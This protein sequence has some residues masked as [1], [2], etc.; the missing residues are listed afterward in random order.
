MEAGLYGV[1]GSILAFC[2]MEV[3]LQLLLQ[4]CMHYAFQFS[5]KLVAAKQQDPA[6]QG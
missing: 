3:G 5:G 1:V 6:A 4:Q 2:G